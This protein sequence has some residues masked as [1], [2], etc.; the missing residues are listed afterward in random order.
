MKANYNQQTVANL[1]QSQQFYKGLTLGMPRR[2][3]RS[4]FDSADD[5]ALWFA[6]QLDYIEAQAYNVLYPELS[7]LNLFPVTTR[8]SAGAAT[9]TYRSYGKTGESRIIG[10]YADDFPRVDIV[11]KE[12]TVHIRA[13]GESYGYNVQ[14][15]REAIM[16]NV[17][18][19]AERAE[20]ARY[21]ND[22]L[23]NQLAWAGDQANKIYGVFSEENGIPLFV[24]P[25]GAAG[26]TRWEMKT[27]MEILNDFI[28]LRKFI[29]QSTKGVE[30]PDT[31]AL[32]ESSINFLSRP[33]QIDVNQ[34]SYGSILNYL[35]DNLKWLK[36]IVGVNE[37]EE[38]S[39][40]TN[41]FSTADEPVGTAFLYTNDDRKLSVEIPLPFIQHPVQ[42]KGLQSEILCESRTAGAIVKYPMSAL[43][44]PGI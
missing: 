12:S 14:E 44:A 7:A 24:L 9:Y 23:T 22:R 36:E 43:I 15:A 35:L 16:A 11:A 2:N 29:I 32:P 37:L 6:R 4:N 13:I 20:S 27:P 3:G 18:L 5:P 8:A 28:L 17:S 30:K 26:S 40:D 21:A 25:V 34:G 10:N 41:I 31:M 39:F 19:E 1:R 42:F 38:D 33:F